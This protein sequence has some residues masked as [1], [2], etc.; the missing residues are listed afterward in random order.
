MKKTIILL[1]LI[2]ILLSG[3][4]ESASSPALITSTQTLPAPTNT[5]SPTSTL[6]PTEAGP[7]EGDTYTVTE[8]GHMYEYTY[9]AEVGGKVR[10]LGSYSLLDFDNNNYGQVALRISDEINGEK[11]IAIFNL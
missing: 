11:K 3:C 5:E 9:N 7:K 1:I 4:G 10:A 8:N 2:V 6:T